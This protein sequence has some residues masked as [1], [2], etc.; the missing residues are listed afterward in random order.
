MG[1]ELVCMV[2][3]AGQSSSGKAH[4]DADE[5]RF[6]GDFRLR[7]PFK[8]IDAL[9]AIDGELTV[10]H[11]DGPAV[12]EL[13]KQAERWAARI[14]NPPSRLDKLGVKPGQRIGVIDLDDAAFVDELRAR[15]DGVTVGEPPAAA[16]MVFLGV[17]QPAALAK[18]A[19]LR[20]RIRPNGG[21]WVISPKG[22]K[23]LR[24]LEVFAAAKAAGLVD[25]KVAAFSATHTANKLVIPVASR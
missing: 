13:G 6:R 7:I 1:A 17:D 24:D 4:L 15:S 3:W 11:R 2:R 12:F 8:E 14:S 9:E 10:H 18:I 20:E 25:V 21:I 23:D 16:D 19:P 22:R 5:L